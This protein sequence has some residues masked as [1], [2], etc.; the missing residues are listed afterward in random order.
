MPSILPILADGKLVSNFKAKSGLFNS[1]FAAQYS[2]VKNPST[3]P[4]FKYRTDKL[5]TSLLQ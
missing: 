4:K 1:H 5:L 3:L 2:P